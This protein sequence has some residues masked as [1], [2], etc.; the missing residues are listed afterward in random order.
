MVKIGV[1]FLHNH[2]IPLT[3]FFDIDIPCVYVIFDAD[4]ES[5]EKMIARHFLEFMNSLYEAI[6]D[7][8]I[9]T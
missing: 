6:Y 2:N 3:V 9:L 7:L 5:M 1:W 8:G 4:Y